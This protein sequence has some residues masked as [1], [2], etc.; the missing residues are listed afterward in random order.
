MKAQSGRNPREEISWRLKLLSCEWSLLMPVSFCLEILFSQIVF[1]NAK[2]WNAR[3]KHPGSFRNRSTESLSG[4]WL[5][6]PALCASFPA[7]L[8]RWHPGWGSPLGRV[9]GCAPW[10]SAGQARRVCLQG[11]SHQPLKKALFNF[12]LWIRAGDKWLSPLVLSL[13]GSERKTGVSS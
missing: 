10:L 7:R 1:Q 2:Q 3:I 6:S 8:P 13:C 11:L 9:C 4:H 5:P 12:C